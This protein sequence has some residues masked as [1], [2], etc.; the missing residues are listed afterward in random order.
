MLLRVIEKEILGDGIS[1]AW[2]TEEMTQKA[3]YLPIG[4]KKSLIRKNFLLLD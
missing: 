3:W 2:E 1:M 4:A